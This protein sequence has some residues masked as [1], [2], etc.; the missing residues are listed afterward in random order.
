MIRLNKY[1][2]ENTSL[3]RRDADKAVADGRVTVNGAVAE[4]P[5]VQVDETSVVTLDGG[6]VGVEDFFY[7][8]FYKPVKVLTAYG[9]G[10]GKETL[11][12]FPK[13]AEKKPAYS[14]RLDYDS[15]GLI[16]FSNDGDFI[17]KL[18]KSDEKIQKEYI[19]SVTR[20]LHQAQVDE[21]KRGISYEGID[22]LPCIVTEMD[23][24]RYRVILH[25]GK[26][27]QIRNMFRHFNI[28][29]KRL[30]RVRIGRVNLDGLKAGEIRVLS[31]KDLEGML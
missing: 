16:I 23:E 26:K 27:R 3:S 8:A 14:G 30:K 1:L 5:W 13:L 24:R 15:E 12:I 17:R 6:K 22:Y 25:E 19:V 29:V 2:A 10:Q 28:Q 7:W 21:L 31:R 4:G 20:R 18:Q 11:D 9:D